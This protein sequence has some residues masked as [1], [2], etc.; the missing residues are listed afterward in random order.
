LINLLI[1]DLE[2]DQNGA[3]DFSE[4]QI[5]LNDN[6]GI[7]EKLSNGA[8]R[9]KKFN[10]TKLKK[11][12][13]NNSNEYSTVKIRNTKAND[14][15]NHRRQSSKQI[16]I[17]PNKNKSQ[18]DQEK[19]IDLLS[20]TPEKNSYEIIYENIK[21]R[22]DAKTLQNNNLNNNNNF[23]VSSRNIVSNDSNRALRSNNRVLNETIKA[24]HNP[25]NNNFS[26]LRNNIN[27]HYE[28]GWSP[29]LNSSICTYYLRNSNCSSK[30]SKKEDSGNKKSL[31]GGHNDASTSDEFF[32]DKF[33]DS[34]MFWKNENPPGCGFNNL[35]NTCFLN[36]VL[37]CILYTPPLKNYFDLSDHSKTCEIDGVCFL[38]EYGKLSKMIGMNFLFFL[39]K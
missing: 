39:I 7:S 13:A 24:N 38:C 23:I 26:F 25:C 32:N 18:F 21:D 4:V 16:F 33:I 6:K 14:K 19:V 2:S 29:K 10:D 22:K 35:G 11:I 30:N 9:N 8:K 17:T 20:E 36:S 31:D 15:E 28:N 3:Y 27:N 5:D 12:R 34:L 1:I 37:Q